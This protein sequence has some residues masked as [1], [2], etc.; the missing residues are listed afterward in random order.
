MMRWMAV[1]TLAL[2]L[3]SCA[4]AVFADYP[5]RA[6]AEV[7]AIDIQIGEP[8]PAV[9]VTVNG[10]LVV[11]GEH[12]GTI[13]IENVPVG[14]AKVVVSASGYPYEPLDR[15]FLVDVEPDGTASVIVG[16]PSRSGAFYVVTA[17][18][19]GLLFCPPAVVVGYDR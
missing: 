16:A 12:T 11:S 17:L 9:Y 18:L 1:F 8:L 15:E 13:L 5:G 6:R 14:P 2:F 4:H 19:L 10:R 3:S 7:G